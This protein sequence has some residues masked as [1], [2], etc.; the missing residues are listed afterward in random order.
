MQPSASRLTCSPVLPRRAYSIWPSLLECRRSVGASYSTRPRMA[1]PWPLSVRGNTISA[2]GP[3]LRVPRAAQELW[4]FRAPRAAR[5]A[6]IGAP[7]GAEP[8]TSFD[9]SMKLSSSTS[10]PSR[11][12]AKSDGF[13]ALDFTPPT[14]TACGLSEVENERTRWVASAR[15]RTARQCKSVMTGHLRFDNTG[16]QLGHQ[17]RRQQV[18]DG[19]ERA[20]DR[21]PGHVDAH[22]PQLG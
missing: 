6:R 9:C 20:D 22:R 11:S 10:W 13:F 16:S 8:T 19:E 12:R 5:E 1:S 15:A 3:V 14:R 17:R 18:S 4:A 21:N 7:G 2:G